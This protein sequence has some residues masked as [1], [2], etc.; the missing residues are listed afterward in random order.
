MARITI[1]IPEYGRRE[2]TIKC[3]RSICETTLNSS[4]VL[5]I[6]LSND[7]Y[8]HDLSLME[9]EELQI[10][11]PH[12]RIEICNWKENVQYAANVNRMSN[13]ILSTGVP[14]GNIFIVNND[15][16]FH[17]D[18]L[19][20]MT[21]YLENHL[22]KSIVGPAII[23]KSNKARPS[24]H[25]PN[26][27]MFVDETY[28]NMKNNFINLPKEPTMLS[29][30]CFGLSIKKW[31]ELGG[32]D[33]QR[34]KAYYE[35]DDIGIRAIKAGCKPYILYSAKIEHD[36]NSTYDPTDNKTKALIAISKANFKNKWEPDGII[37][38]PDGFYSQDKI[39]N[40]S[41]LD[42]RIYYKE[43]GYIK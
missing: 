9:I 4:R 16:I 25:G 14:S 28:E 8:P 34:F 11:Y 23:I 13:K 5:Y 2:L 1:I 19:N 6:Y 15:V 33:C 42:D 22:H 21:D 31:K 17:K 12:T 30:C 3:I 43:A 35:D 20:K 24:G 32:F 41:D 36:F 7:A 26:L 40:L 27:Q 18:A 39:L 38:S 37:W 29:G 10:Q